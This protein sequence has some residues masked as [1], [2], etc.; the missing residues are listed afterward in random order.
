M[1]SGKVKWWNVVKGFGFI[2]QED[3][4]K[5]VFVHYKDIQGGP[6]RKNLSEGEVVSF[7]IIESAKGPKAHNVKHIDARP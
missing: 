1:A 6:G 4:G 3:G 2:E 7:E 5:D